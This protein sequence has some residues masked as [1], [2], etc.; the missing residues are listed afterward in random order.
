[1]SVSTGLAG[2]LQLILGTINLPSW[3]TVGAK[4]PPN[5]AKVEHMPTAEFLMEVG[6]NS[7]VYKK[8]FEKAAADPNFPT[9]ANKS[10]RLLSLIN[11]AHIQEMP[12]RI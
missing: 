1:M 12:L 3:A 10:L 9:K 7:A 5:L 4:I 8:T 6:N 2:L 11:P